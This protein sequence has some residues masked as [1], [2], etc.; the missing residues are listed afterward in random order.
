MQVAFIENGAANMVHKL[1]KLLGEVVGLLKVAVVPKRLQ[2]KQAF[3][4]V[5]PLAV[6]ARGCRAGI[7]DRFDKPMKDRNRIVRE[8]VLVLK[9]GFQCSRVRLVRLGQGKVIAPC[10]VIFEGG[11]QGMGPRV[12]QEPVMLNGL[13]HLERLPWCSVLIRA[14]ER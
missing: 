13:N 11:K 1:C 7:Q 2:R 4:R 3:K 8:R 9:N 6:V 5:R 12:E 10:I 14:T